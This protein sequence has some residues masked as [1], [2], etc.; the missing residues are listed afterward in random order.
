[1]SIFA[2]IERATQTGFRLGVLVGMLGLTA[3]MDNYGNYFYDE[4]VAPQARHPIIMK[5]QPEIAFLSLDYS[6]D[7]LNQ[8]QRS[9]I[10]RFAAFYKTH[11]LGPVEIDIKGWQNSTPTREYW[12]GKVS[13]VLAEMGVQSL[14]A[15]QTHPKPGQGSNVQVNLSYS[16]ITPTPP[17]CAKFSRGL[18]ENGD[19]DFW[20]NFGCAEQNNLAAMISN[21]RELVHPAEMGSA[22][23]ERR[24]DAL[25]KYRQGLISGSQRSAG[26]SGVVSSVAAQ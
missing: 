22:D 1:M 15:L 7:N 24:R 12:A 2:K 6:A 25:G 23:T 4:P 10:E 9:Q 8:V 11:G 17:Q 26:E 5:K 20:E 3:C 19:N 14:I 18:E 16:S 13:D 21:P